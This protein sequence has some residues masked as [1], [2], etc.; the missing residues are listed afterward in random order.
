MPDS[1]INRVAALREK[2]KRTVSELASDV[3]VPRQT[4]YAIESGAYTPNTALALKLARALGAS[5][6][7][8][9]ALPDAEPENVAESVTLLP[10]GSI[11]RPGQ[12]V[13]LCSVGRR[14][15][16]SAPSPLSCY[17]PTGDASLLSSSRAQL[18]VPAE[19]FGDRLLMAG[20]DPAAPL[21]AAHLNG[22]G[23][24]LLLAYRNSSE[25]LRLLKGKYIHIA[26]THLQGDD[27]LLA[28]K[29]MFP[30]NSAVVISLAAW[31]IGI[32][33]AL[34]SKKGIRALDDFARPDV[35]VANREPG[36]ATRLLLDS[37]LRRNKISPSRISG[38]HRTADSHLLAGWYVASGT[39]DVAISTRAVACALHL[40]FVPLVTERYNLVLR[41]ANLRTANVQALLNA[42]TSLSF[43]R[44]L[45]SL[46]GYDTSVTG[47]QLM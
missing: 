1:V 7:D 16:A 3:G 34:N 40:H 18:H 44:Q 17:L 25:S 32:V 31:E 30:R 20:C 38:D 35:S 23:P 9:F 12:P 37:H 28:L 41:K 2:G 21:L 22:N 13:Q 43:R 10:G 47:Q 46:G 26:G 27:S 33:T 19:Q 4:I 42:L 11:P 14:T 5:V 36:S 45:E 8:L 24:T 6:E 15:V 39:A 29:K